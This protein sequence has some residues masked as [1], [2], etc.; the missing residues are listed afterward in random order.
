MVCVNLAPVNVIDVGHI[1]LS[2][3]WLHVLLILGL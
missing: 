2:W 1:D 3:C